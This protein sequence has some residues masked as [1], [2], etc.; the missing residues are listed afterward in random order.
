MTHLDRVLVKLAATGG[1]PFPLPPP[2]PSFGAPRQLHTPPAMPAD[3]A[4]IAP[5]ARRAA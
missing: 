1:M 5:A 2:M 4:T 3:G